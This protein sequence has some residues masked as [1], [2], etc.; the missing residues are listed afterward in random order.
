MELSD[1]PDELT[2]AILRSLVA[3]TS[4]PP[5]L[6]VRTL[7]RLA[8][9]SKNMR[10]LAQSDG[11]WRTCY[12]RSMRWVQRHSCG[13]ADAACDAMLER[14]RALEA[15]GAPWKA[16]LCGAA[17]DLARTVA[18]ADDVRSNQWR[19]R[20][21][22]AAGGL[23]SNAPYTGDFAYAA[24]DAA[25][26]LLW[27]APSSGRSPFTP[28]YPPLPWTLSNGGAEMTIYNFPPHRVARSALDGS[29]LIWNDNV[30]LWSVDP[31]AS[32]L[33]TAL[34]TRGNSEFRAGDYANALWTYKQAAATMLGVRGDE[35]T[36]Q[37]MGFTSRVTSDQS[38]MWPQHV[39][40]I[41]T[42]ATLW[43]QVLSNVLAAMLKLYESE[44]FC[45]SASVAQMLEDLTTATE[46]GKFVLAC[47]EQRPGSVDPALSKKVWARLNKM[48]LF[49]DQITQKAAREQAMGT[50]SYV[51]PYRGGP[52]QG[53]SW[54]SPPAS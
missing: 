1:L 22:P 26:Q 40:L 41:D 15:R 5:G 7:G 27:L 11:L 4:A 49:R 2:A 34:K 29:W 52:A 50:Q 30:A 45:Q 38:G 33:A 28:Q 6:S 42:E 32:E 46:A 10:R 54:R 14:C 9:C 18:T 24:A 35:A 23:N 13:D 37:A 31:T 19:M 44:A 53:H 3:D 25:E 16:L 47:S 43:A 36:M 8:M 12:A 21:L 39:W 17:A 20:F 51:P 48:A